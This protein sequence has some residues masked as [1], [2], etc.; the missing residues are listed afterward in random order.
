[1]NASR[2]AQHKH[3]TNRAPFSWKARARSFKYAWKGIVYT[4]R[5]QHN[6]WLH[7]LAA[8]LTILMAWW[9]D[10]PSTKW[11]LLIFA[12]GLVLALEIIN[13]AIEALADHLHPEDHPMIG[14]VKDLAAGAVL[15]AAITAFIIGCCIFGPALTHYILFK[16]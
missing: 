7:S 6:M 5:T 14:L 10:L 9:L 12:M 8:C 1:M 4:F 13:T 11:L 15:I 16:A 3:Q 2:G